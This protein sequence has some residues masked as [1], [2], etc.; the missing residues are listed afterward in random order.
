MMNAAAVR[1]IS[2]AIIALLQ[3]TEAAT[4]SMMLPQAARNKSDLSADVVGNLGVHYAL[5]NA[6]RGE[7]QPVIMGRLLA[8][9]DKNISAR[10]S[11]AGAEALALTTMALHQLHSAV[12]LAAVMSRARAPNC[13]LTFADIV[14]LLFKDKVTD[15]AR[16]CGWTAARSYKIALAIE[17]GTTEIQGVAFRIG[18]ELL[19][20]CAVF[21]PEFIFGIENCHLSLNMLRS[22]NVW[23]VGHLLHDIDENAAKNFRKCMRKRFGSLLKLPEYKGFKNLFDVQEHSLSKELLGLIKEIQV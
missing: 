13:S 20:L 8:T 6:F 10:S 4:Q 22:V 18:R 14:R 15:N 9:L 11:L 12:S 1:G 17:M 7:N 21:G 5:E 19:S 3:D 23:A 2:D 16:T